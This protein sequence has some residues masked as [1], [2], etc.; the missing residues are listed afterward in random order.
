MPC[1]GAENERKIVGSKKDLQ[2]KRKIAL[3]ASE[4]PQSQTPLRQNNDHRYSIEACDAGRFR[5]P[6]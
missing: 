2:G 1:H 5:D 4:E 6:E 3:L